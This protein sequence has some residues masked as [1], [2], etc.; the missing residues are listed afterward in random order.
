MF[1][2]GVDPGLVT[3]LV[4]LT[5]RSRLYAIQ[6]DAHSVEYMLRILTEDIKSVGVRIAVEDFIVSTRRA[7]PRIT[8]LGA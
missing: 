4:V 7:E 5:D 6:C 1:I 3:G 8:A 2:I